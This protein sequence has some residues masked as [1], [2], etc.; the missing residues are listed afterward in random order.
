VVTVVHWVLLLNLPSKEF[1]SVRKV[2]LAHVGVVDFICFEFQ[3]GVDLLDLAS[4]SLDD[5][6]HFLVLYFFLLSIEKVGDLAL[7]FD[8]WLN[9]NVS[10][11]RPC[12]LAVILMCLI[13][14]LKFLQKQFVL[15]IMDFDHL[16]L[17]QTLLLISV[18]YQ[19]FI[20]FLI[21]YFQTVL[22]LSLLDVVES[23]HRR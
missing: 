10:D 2:A 16:L 8:S 9:D 12:L 18:V 6:G 17:R 1:D 20:K 23:S 5:V 11:Q 4:Y 15:N 13:F 7:L 3:D 22:L 21:L 14:L 19:C